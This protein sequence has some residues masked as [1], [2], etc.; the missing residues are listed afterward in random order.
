[1]D[2][3]QFNSNPAQQI[4]PFEYPDEI[5]SECGHNV[6]IPGVI[7]K[8][9]PG[10]LLGSGSPEP[11]SVPIKVACCAKCGAL[12]PSDKKAYDEMSGKKK[13]NETKKSGSLIL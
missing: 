13:D 2:E 7:F 11:E 10:I 9:V 8:M 12:A 5:C 1:M 4:N 3:Q 6:F